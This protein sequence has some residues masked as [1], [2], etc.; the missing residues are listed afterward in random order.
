MPKQCPTPNS[1]TN[2]AS[3]AGY[4]GSSTFLSHAHRFFF[5]PSSTW[6][7]VHRLNPGNFQFK[8]TLKHVNTVIGPLKLWFL[9]LECFGFNN[10]CMYLCISHC[11]LANISQQSEQSGHDTRIWYHEWASSKQNLQHHHLF[12]SCTH[13]FFFFLPF[14]MWKPFLHAKSR[15]LPK[16][17]A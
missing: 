10:I 7:P 17:L 14:F 13:W 16:W 1:K 4:T 8:E 5:S 11:S 9:T 15:E 2:P 6:V 12:F 3:Y